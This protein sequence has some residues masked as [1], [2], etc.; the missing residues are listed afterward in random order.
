MLKIRYFAI[1]LPVEFDQ[2]LAFVQANSSAEWKSRLSLVHYSATD[3]VL[4]YIVERVL[5][6][7]RYLE[8]GEEV[9]EKAV[10]MDRYSVRLFKT[11]NK[12]YLSLL[13]PGR[14]TRIVVDILDAIFPDGEYFIDPVEVNSVLIQRHIGKF[15]SFKL[16]SAK[17]KDFEVYSGAVGRLEISSQEGLKPDIAPFLRDKFYRVDSFTYEVTH[18]FVKGSIQYAKNGTVRISGPL[19]ESAFPMFESCL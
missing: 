9:I 17:I 11:S 13:D 4:A 19:I 5:P 10:T 14:S 15:D 1:R 12:I 8:N 3:I 18:N 6:I 2:V 7:R 16:V